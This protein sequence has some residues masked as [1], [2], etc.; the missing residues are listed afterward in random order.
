[1][2][3]LASNER[4]L[5]LV[6]LA[7]VFVASNLFVVRF[8]LDKRR[9]TARSLVADKAK[10]AEYTSLSSAAEMISSG[11][12]WLAANPPPVV[13]ADEANTRLL[14]EVR[15]SAESAGLTIV[16]ETLMPAEGGQAAVLQTKVGGPFA[17]FATFLFGLQSPG[18]WKSID[19]ILIRSDKEPPNVIAEIVVRQHYNERETT[20]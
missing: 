17:G 11:S 4:R 6:F 18:A 12:E 2:R 8:W 9:D 14:G 5:L 7:A 3:K 13:S 20:P 10:L 19:R 16:E 15:S 1:M